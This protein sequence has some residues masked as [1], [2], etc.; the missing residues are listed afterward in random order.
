MI[1][2]G[3]RKKDY[4]TLCVKIKKEYIHLNV[5]Q[6][7]QCLEFVRGMQEIVGANLIFLCGI[8]KP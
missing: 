3:E 6:M 4:W 8:E 7:A 1:Y 5:G 2:K